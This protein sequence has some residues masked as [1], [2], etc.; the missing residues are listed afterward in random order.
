MDK[1]QVGKNYFIYD[2][3]NAFRIYNCWLSTTGAGGPG[4]GAKEGAPQTTF[5]FS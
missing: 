1:D 3:K 2:S 5:A 4:Q